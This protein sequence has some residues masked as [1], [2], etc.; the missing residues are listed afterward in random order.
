MIKGE[1]ENFELFAILSNVSCMPNFSRKFI[2][3][4]PNQKCVTRNNKSIQFDAEFY[5]SSVKRGG[6]IIFTRITVSFLF[7][8]FIFNRQMKL[9]GGF[10]FLFHFC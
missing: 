3:K 10:S 8:Q 2:K 6:L 5:K 7:L 4:N 9:V 1:D